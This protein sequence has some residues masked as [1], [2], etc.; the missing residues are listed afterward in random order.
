MLKISV[1]ILLVAGLFIS[2]K[3]IGNASDLSKTSKNDSNEE[4]QSEMKLFA[5]FKTSFFFPV[6]NGFI[7]NSEDS[8]KI[9]TISEYLK[10]NIDQSCQIK[11]YQHEIELPETSAKRRDFISDLLI[12][13]G[14]KPNRILTKL[15]R[16]LIPQ[17]EEDKFTEEELVHARRVDL[18]II[19]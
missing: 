10:V 6:D 1:F 16:P 18:S 15:E 7:L 2:C 11:C 14:V 5:G 13:N 9:G 3:T 17:S 12:R 19:R 8:L 4:V